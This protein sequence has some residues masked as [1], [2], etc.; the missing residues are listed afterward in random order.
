MRL[1]LFDVGIGVLLLSAIAAAAYMRPRI[2]A[3]ILRTYGWMLVALPLPAAVAAHM[4]MHLP[5]SVDQTLF[6]AGAAAFALGAPILLR[7][8][9]EGWREEPD[10]GAPPWWPAFERE[11]REYERGS[12]RRP[13]ALHP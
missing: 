7:R 6:V 5:T 11:L 3:H 8:D 12:T 9:D 1:L 10:D 4:T 13:K 2:D